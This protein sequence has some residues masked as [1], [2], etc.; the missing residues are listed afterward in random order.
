VASNLNE[1]VAKP[2]R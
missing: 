1:T 2:P